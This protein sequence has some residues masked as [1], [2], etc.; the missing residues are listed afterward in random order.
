MD[1]TS[2]FSCSMLDCIKSTE[3]ACDN[4]IKHRE[5]NT[6][7]VLK[8]IKERKNPISSIVFIGSGTSST[9]PITASNFVEKVT[10]MHTE[11]KYPDVF[12]HNTYAYDPNALYVFISQ[13]G[14]S[15]VCQKALDFVSEKGYSYV[16]I[17]E[18]EDTPMAKDA[19]AVLIMDCGIEEYPMRTVG[20]SAS[21]LTCMLLAL[22][23]AKLYK[24]IDEKEY[25]AYIEQIKE[26][27]KRQP[28]VIEKTLEWLNVA[29]R[30]MLR[31]DLI[32]FT[33]ADELYGVAL[34]GA[35]K[36]WET[37]QTASVGYELEE[38]LHGPNYGY[39]SRHC[40]IVLNK[41]GRENDKARALA[42]Y[43]K[44]VWG[45]GLLVGVNPLDENDLEL[46][47]VSNDFSCIDFATVCQVIAYKTARDQGRDLYKKHDNSLMDSY[48]KTHK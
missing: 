30:Q 5:K 18:T 16:V 23:I 39:N 27:G 35:M 42:S 10:K 24:R 28:K 25:I 8:L 21:V 34:E 2:R 48:F 44:K 20:Y 4:I 40:I 37:L 29:K 7:K 36:V 6:F 33:G 31:S 11:V 45:N 19:K 46:E 1:K 38:G 15:K 22:E 32:V 26:T 13:T 43:M 9:A 3:K 17:S 12:L 14:T 47:D 41:G